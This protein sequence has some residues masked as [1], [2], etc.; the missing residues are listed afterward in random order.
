MKQQVDAQNSDL[1][2]AHEILLLTAEQEIDNLKFLANHWEEKYQMTLRVAKQYW[3]RCD[4]G[5]YPC[6]ICEEYQ[7]I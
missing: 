2:V 4:C 6:D 5:T 7:K 1:Q 3:Q